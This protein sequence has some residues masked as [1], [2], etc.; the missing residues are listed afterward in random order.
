MSAIPI[1]SH[2]TENDAF[3]VLCSAEERVKERGRETERG[4]E[5]IK[6]GEERI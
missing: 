1:S 3:A 5:K 4:I 6:K 2:I